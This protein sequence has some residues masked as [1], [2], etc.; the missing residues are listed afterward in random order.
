MRSS[1]K[2]LLTSL[3][4][5]FN[6]F[7]ANKALNETKTK[8]YLPQIPLPS[9]GGAYCNFSNFN[10]QIWLLINHLDNNQRLFYL[11]ASFQNEAKQL[12]SPDDDFDYLHISR[13]YT[14]IWKQ[15]TFSSFLY[16]FN[17]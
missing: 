15:A 10:S 11:K 8:V 7:N 5:E 2:L 1:L 9:I 12:E 14:Q 13:L 16:F 4:T 6:I 17:F 3:E